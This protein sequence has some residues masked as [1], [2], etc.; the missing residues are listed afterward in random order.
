[1]SDEKQAE[2][3]GQDVI[4][5]PTI[6]EEKFTTAPEGWSFAATATTP[7]LRFDQPGLVVTLPGGETSVAA[8]WYDKARY[9]DFALLVTLSL[10]A[11]QEPTQSYCGVS[12]RAMDDKNNYRLFLDGEG[13]YRLT[14][15]MDN[16]STALVDWTRAPAILPGIGSKNRVHI[17]CEGP[18]LTV[19]VNG[20][21]IAS[22]H[23]TVFAKGLVALQAQGG[24]KE[25]DSATV[26][27]FEDLELHAP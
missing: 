26:F 19:S 11:G 24:S 25:I 15:R 4:A 17:T 7:P 27:S 21:Q 12:F 13:Y 5:W 8:Y 14:R 22:V 9:S 6:F 18:Q 10:V 3:A 16:V 20:V 2:T 23:D 1:M